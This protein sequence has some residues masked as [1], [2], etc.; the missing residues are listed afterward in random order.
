MEANPQFC[1]RMGKT[2]RELISVIPSY[3]KNY[4]IML[5]YMSINTN[6]FRK[7]TKFAMN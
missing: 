7:L 4:V 6:R 1:D 3:V 5:S 2:Q